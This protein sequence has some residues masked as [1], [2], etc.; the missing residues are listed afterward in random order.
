MRLTEEQW[1]TFARD[2]RRALSRT[3][4][5]WKLPGEIT[6]RDGVTVP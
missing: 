4:P 2:L 6:L 5:K 3:A 1:R